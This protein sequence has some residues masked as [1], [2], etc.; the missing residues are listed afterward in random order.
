MPELT[1][2][3]IVPMLRGYGAFYET[4]DPTLSPWPDDPDG[5]QLRLVGALR[6]LAV[7][8][9]TRGPD[10]ALSTES[11]RRMLADR[12]ARDRPTVTVERRDE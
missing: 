1:W 4:G 3:D 6:D 7:L 8:A 11:I 12:L 9:A 2:D 5:G 10:A